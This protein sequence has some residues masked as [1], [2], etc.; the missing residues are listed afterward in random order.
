ME[1][2]YYIK[3]DLGRTENVIVKVILLWFNM[4]V[5]ESHYYII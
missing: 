5:L 1:K 3:V 4:S 2:L